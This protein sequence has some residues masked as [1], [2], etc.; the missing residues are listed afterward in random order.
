MFT[1]KNINKKRSSSYAKIRKVCFKETGVIKVKEGHFRMI[2]GS[3]KQYSDILLGLHVLIDK[4]SKY[5]AEMEGN[6]SEIEFQKL[7]E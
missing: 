5:M 1:T 2:M 6:K 3:L 4:V 7:I